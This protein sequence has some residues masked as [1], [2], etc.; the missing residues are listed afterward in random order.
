M[1]Q[2]RQHSVVK[3]PLVRVDLKKLISRYAELDG[4]KDEPKF[5]ELEKLFELLQQVVLQDAYFHDAESLASSLCQVRMNAGL[6]VKLDV[7][8]D[9]S[10][11]VKI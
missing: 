11:P 6:A 2:A 10:K 9:C 5:L 1:A 7:K 4:T 8:V 3:V